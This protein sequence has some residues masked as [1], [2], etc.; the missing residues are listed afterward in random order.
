[1]NNK[2]L[3]FLKCVNNNCCGFLEYKSTPEETL[4]CMDC[5][6]VYNFID[7]VPIILSKKSLTQ[8]NKRFWD[9]EIEAVS[10]TDK[11]DKNLKNEGNPWSQYTHD[12]E[13]YGIKRL[14]DDKNFSAKNKAI[15]DCGS[16]N[17]RFLSIYK[18][19]EF[20][21][22]LDTSL[23]LLKNSKLRDNN[24]ICICA[25][26]ENI[27]IQDYC[28]DLSVSIRVFQHLRNPKK[29]FTEMSR[30]TKPKG[31]VALEVYNKFNLKE[32]YKKIRMSKTVRKIK[33]W[34]LDYDRYYSF[35]EIKSWAQK[36]LIRPIAWSGC[37]WGIHFYLFDLIR[38]RNNS[39][40][41]QKKI[42]NIFF[43]LEKLIGTWFFFSKTLEKICFVGSMHSTNQNSIID[44]VQEKLL[45]IKKTFFLK[46]DIKKFN[47]NNSKYISNDKDHLIR[48][49]NW[50]KKAQDAFPDGGISRGFSLISP[51]SKANRLG[52]QATYPE[53]S[54]YLLSSLLET[55]RHLKYLDLEKR[56]KRLANFLFQIS[57]D[58]KVKG[59]SLNKIENY[60]IFDTAQVARGLLSYFNETKKKIYLQRAI[61]C[62][63]FIIN[64]E[65][66]GTG[67]FNND[68]SAKNSIMFLDNDGCNI[69]IAP[70][71]FE[72][73]KVTNEE[74]YLLLAKRIINHT[75]SYRLKNGF[76]KN[77]DFYS[78]ESI[79][80]HNLGYIVEA[81]IDCS[82][83]I[84][85]Q[86][87]LDIANTSLD[88]VVNLI[89]ENGFLP[90]RINSKMKKITN[91]IC[92]TGS[93][94]IALC[95]LKSHK[96][97]KN[98]IYNFNGKSILESLK[99]YQNNNLDNFGGGVGAMWGSWP[100]DGSYQS[101]TAIN[102]A[103]KFFID[104]L[105]I[106]GKLEV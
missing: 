46:N 65:N 41:T 32:I 89:L 75:L 19:A 7:G 53:T 100:I 64:A 67:T 96:I 37:G 49:I 24:L 51:N 58:G 88:A 72:L 68:Y 97:K 90:S 13:I 23:L 87:I 86:K 105:I 42:F 27:P 83:I 102:W 85:D 78:N 43:K 76:F 81:L 31:M 70:F 22:A 82:K 84:G 15:V 8:F 104:L 69:Y 80:T 17:G 94:Q 25:D 103:N 63:T 39:E 30:I 54:G 48:S 33:P 29:G 4:K 18:E 14:L 28:I 45:K 71:L 74:K 20:K 56:I 26:I 79:L 52:W 62:G 92:L 1:M 55:N 60:S 77:S 50:I 101:N 36:N 47:L 16:G 95:L 59:G 35:L 93:A 61:E 11:Y 91:D 2:I 38:F 73:S 106:N 98:D 6:H 99:K 12:S 9:Q 34:A 5:N 57:I 44:K 40:D 3:S 10:Y 21:F 66:N